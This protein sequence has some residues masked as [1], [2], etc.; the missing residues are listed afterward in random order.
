MAELFHAGISVSG[1]V[2]VNV[3]QYDRDCKLTGFAPFVIPISGTI[4]GSTLT[5][6][7]KTD[8]QSAP[9]QVSLSV[10]GSSMTFALSVAGDE[11]V[12]NAGSLSRTSSLQPIS[13]LSGTYDGTFTN[14]L[15]L[16]G[17]PPPFT[18]SG[19]VS[20]TLLQAGSMVTACF[21]VTGGLTD[22]VDGAN[23]RVTTQPRVSA[24]AGLTDGEK[25]VAT[26]TDPDWKGHDVT[27]TVSGNTINGEITRN[28]G[29]SLVFSV[30]RTSSGFPPPCITDFTVAPST[31]IVGAW[32]LSWSSMN[33][34]SATIDNGVGAVPVGGTVTVSPKGSTVYTLTAT[35]IGGSTATT[36]FVSFP[37]RRAARH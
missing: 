27:A 4:A 34:A 32:V 26:L 11:G 23:C 30:T 24:L 9:G 3:P 28:A 7:F 22:T 15:F 18:Y 16:C 17:K 35:G 19:E 20:M 6:A 29:E 37:R 25:M 14:T 2:S 33:A 10:A 8:Q 31:L 12:T 21:A 13:I 1:A 5:V 36:A